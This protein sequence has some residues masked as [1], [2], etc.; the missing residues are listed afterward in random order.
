MNDKFNTIMPETT[1]KVLCVMID[2]RMTAEGYR[3]NFIPRMEA[4][5]EKYGELRILVYFKNY[6]GWDE[7]AAMMD[8]AAT[9][10]TASK[11]KK[12]ALINPPSTMLALAKI[13]KPLTPGE[14]RVFTEDELP[15]ALAWV[16]E[17]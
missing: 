13:R 17:D 5:L 14:T 4:M 8:F 10:T 9:Q 16:F 2:R 3:E 11:L 1:D 15:Q 12:C 7:E 6:Q